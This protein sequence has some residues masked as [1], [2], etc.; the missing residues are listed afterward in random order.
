MDSTPATITPAPV[1]RRFRESLQARTNEK[2]SP[3]A[4]FSDRL[5]A[6]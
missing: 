5:K 6:I 3:G 4:D 2:R 1:F